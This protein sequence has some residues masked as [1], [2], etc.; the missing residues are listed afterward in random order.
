MNSWTPP[1]F[2]KTKMPSVLPVGKTVGKLKVPSVFSVGSPEA[3]LGVPSVLPGRQGS[4]TNPTTKMR[5]LIF[6]KKIKPY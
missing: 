4:T 3:K 2:Q 6:A 5:D 1:N